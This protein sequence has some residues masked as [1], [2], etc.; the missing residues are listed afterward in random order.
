MIQKTVKGQGTKVYLNFISTY[1]YCNFFYDCL[2]YPSC[3]C[4]KFCKLF[5]LVTGT[6]KRKR[7]Y[8]Q[9]LLIEFEYIIGSWEE[10]S[11]LNSF[12]K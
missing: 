5:Y 7:Q 12:N 2:T 3:D 1:N 8:I 9:N 6:T 4:V 11:F 10:I